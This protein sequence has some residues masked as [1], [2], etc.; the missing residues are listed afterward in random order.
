MPGQNAN[1]LRFK[2]SNFMRQRLILSI[3]T[4]KSI[5]IS[6]IRT[7]DTEPGLREYEVN[8]LRLLDKLMNGMWL[9]VSETGT[10]FS[11]T[12]GSLL[13]GQIDHECCKLRGIGYY[14]EVIFAL[15]PFCK[16]PI[17]ITLRGV[18]NNQCDPSVDSFK[19]GGLSVLKQ[20]IVVDPGIDFKINKRGLEPDGGGEITFTCPSLKLK[21]IQVKEMGKIKK[22]RGIA[23][24]SK[25]SPSMAN[26]FIE[27]AKGE[28]LKFI[29][30]VFITSD[31]LKGQ[32]AGKSPGFGGT[33]VAETTKEIIFTAE[34]NSLPKE[35]QVPEDLGKQAAWLLMEEISRGGLVDSS[36]QGLA[37]IYMAFGQKDVSQM[38]FGP[39]SIYGIEMMRHIIAFLNVMFKLEPYFEEDE[40][41]LKKGTNKV[42]VSGVGIGFNKFS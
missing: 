27:A 15:A 18:T 30:D 42:L 34:K 19:H 17:S 10:S 13:G 38:L 5:Y 16:K 23:F 11:F 7:K 14:L 3:L 22:I 4:G 37:L 31:H 36:F 21:P 24:A 8:L 6:D 40:N 12:P 32:C 28:M 1:V 41:E 25:V 20:F 26:R 39:L 29:P 9:E 35:R 33:L 2:G